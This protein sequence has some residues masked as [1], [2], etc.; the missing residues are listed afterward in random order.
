[1]HAFPTEWARGQFPALQLAIEGQ[2]AI[3]LDGPGGTQ[4]PEPVIKAVCDYY[5]KNNSNLGGAFVTSR[6]T[7]ELVQRARV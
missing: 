2:P 3:F 4:V 7:A 6:N 5:R 1:M